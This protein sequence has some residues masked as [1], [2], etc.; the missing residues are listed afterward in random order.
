[1]EE[2]NRAD[3]AR[4]L[5]RAVYRDLYVECLGHLLLQLSQRFVYFAA[6]GGLQCRC[7][8]LSYSI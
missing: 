3:G 4:R 5:E 2:Q 1:M 8:I 7:P 6:P